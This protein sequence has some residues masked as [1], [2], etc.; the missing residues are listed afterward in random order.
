MADI[1]PKQMKEMR[2][3][4]H[5]ELRERTGAK[6]KPKKSPV[7]AIVAVIIIGLGIFVAMQYK[8]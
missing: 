3:H 2:R 5:T 7:I 6:K 4:D 1:K 8:K